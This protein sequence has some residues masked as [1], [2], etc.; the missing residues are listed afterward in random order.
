VKYDGGMMKMDNIKDVLQK[1]AKDRLKIF[2]KDGTIYTGQILQFLDDGKVL[3]F[4]KYGK[5]AVFS[6]DDVS[7]FYSLP[8]KPSVEE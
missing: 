3:F 8:D 6:I 2:L 5:N 7:H 1:S 4:D